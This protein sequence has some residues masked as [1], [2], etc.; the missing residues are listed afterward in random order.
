LVQV[1][2][3]TS[4]G[5]TALHYATASGDSTSVSVLLKY[6][7]DI[8]AR[9]DCDMTPMHLA[10][11]SKFP[12]GSCNERLS[13]VKLL[14][15]HALSSKATF[16][17]VCAANPLRG[18][19]AGREP[20]D[21]RA[22]TVEHLL[23]C[24]DEHGRTPLDLAFA[25]NNTDVFAAVLPLCE[26]RSFR[27]A[28]CATAILTALACAEPEPHFIELARGIMSSGA[29]SSADTVRHLLCQTCKRGNFELA[30]YIL[31]T[32]LWAA[33]E[34]ELP[35]PTTAPLPSPLP[36][37][38]EA[39]AALLSS[40]DKVGWQP[41]HHAVHS[42]CWRTVHLL[43][44]CW[45]AN[46]FDV[47]GSLGQTSSHPL[48]LNALQL[49]CYLGSV[50]IVWLLLVSLYDVRA[51]GPHGRN[52]LHYISLGPLQGTEPWLF[53]TQPLDAVRVLPPAAIQSTHCSQHQRMHAHLA[54][55]QLG[56]LA[57]RLAVP[58]CADSL[59]AFPHHYAAASGNC[60]LYKLLRKRVGPVLWAAPDNQLRGVLHYACAGGGDHMASCVSDILVSAPGLEH[61]EDA[62]GRI[63]LHYAAQV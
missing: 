59:G 20:S 48:F 18:R 52:I 12:L 54:Y 56:E 29:V 23:C 41:L 5:C 40:R 2:A 45:G 3:A 21:K 49:A 7:A 16:P 58:L 63:P 15:S 62:D 34:A 33:E 50:R 42:G 24:K 4:S 28:E 19:A 11:H 47:G 36:S 32:S 46:E 60:G 55:T 37:I 53:S 39:T 17:C 27:K 57:L 30:H 35:Y 22:T 9:D 51:A 43:V 6:G 10:L 38:P 13:V 1:N 31:Q 61:F 44:Q 14:V 8:A 25:L 26:P